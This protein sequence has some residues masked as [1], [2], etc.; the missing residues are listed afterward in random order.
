MTPKKLAQAGEVVQPRKVNRDKWN[1]PC[2]AEGGRDCFLRIEAWQS[3][4]FDVSCV[5]EKLEFAGRGSNTWEA[6]SLTLRKGWTATAG[7]RFSGYAGSQN[8]GRAE[9]PR[10][11]T[12][13]CVVSDSESFA[14]DYVCGQLRGGNFPPGNL[15][16][17][18]GI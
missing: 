2:T 17:L 1:V 6:E 14:L 18:L 5:W 11:E 16:V 10:G 4:A 8:L 15:E 7:P 3:P 12:Q 9:L 13:A